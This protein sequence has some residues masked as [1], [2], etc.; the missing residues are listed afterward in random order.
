VSARILARMYVSA[1]V[2]ASWNF[3]LSYIPVSVCLSQAGIVSII[4]T[5][6]KIEVLSIGTES[7]VSW[8]CNS[9][10]SSSCTTN[11]TGV[12]PE[13]RVNYFPLSCAWNFVSNSGVRKMSPRYVDRRSCCQLSSTATTVVSLSHWAS[14]S[15]YDTTGVMQRVARVPL[16]QLKF[17]LLQPGPGLRISFFSLWAGS[18]KTM[19]WTQDRQMWDSMKFSQRIFYI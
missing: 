3:S 5:A 16:Q 4:D 6:E 17:A 8:S 13:I 1:S 11:G 7:S 14:R 10:N 9:R 12:S 18:V 2:S 15:V 19:K